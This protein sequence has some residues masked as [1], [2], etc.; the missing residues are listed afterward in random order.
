MF[1]ILTYFLTKIHLYTI[2]QLNRKIQAYEQEMTI[3]TQKKEQ[4]T[5]I[6]EQEI[7]KN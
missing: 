4:V 7:N 2:N 3:L 5:N 6:L 1:K